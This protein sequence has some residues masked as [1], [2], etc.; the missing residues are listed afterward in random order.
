MTFAMSS[1]MINF[2]SLLM[3][4]VKYSESLVVITVEGGSIE[5]DGMRLT[6]VTAST[7]TI[8]CSSVR[9]VPVIEKRD[10]RSTTGITLP[11][12]LI[13]PSMNSG[14]AGYFLHVNDFSN[15]A[16]IYAVCLYVAVKYDE[17]AL[18]E[19]SVLSDMISSTPCI[20]I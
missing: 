16:D 6:S 2:S 5:L 1:K 14:H 18:F 19:T 10:R 7:T 13:T 12:R 20:H 9:T 8:R 15:S 4:P 17:L 11:R 3:I